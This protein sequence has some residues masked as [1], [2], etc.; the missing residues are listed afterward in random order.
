MVLIDDASNVAAHRA[1]I[2]ILN[3]AVNVHH[4]ADVVMRHHF[5]LTPAM[6]GG[7][8]GENF[9][10]NHGRRTDGYV[11]DILQGLDAVLLI[12]GN[13]LVLHTVLPVQEKGRRDLKTSAQG[14]QKAACNVADP[15]TR[16]GLPWFDP[17]RR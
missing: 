1:E 16:P 8:L 4:P 2:A 6:D 9:R 12:L 5:H 15:Y 13:H 10:T 14:G 11:A 7:D 17:Q 3:G